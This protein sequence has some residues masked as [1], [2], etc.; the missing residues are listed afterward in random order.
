LLGSGGFVVLAFDVADRA[1]NL[2]TFGRRSRLADATTDGPSLL[3]VCNG[4]SLFTQHFEDRWE[5]LL[6]NR[7]RDL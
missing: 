1:A 4:Y 3:V 2:T 6:I 7:D 5:V